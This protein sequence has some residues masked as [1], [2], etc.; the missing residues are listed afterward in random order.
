MTVISAAYSDGNEGEIASAVRTLQQSQFKYFFAAITPSAV[1]CKSIIS[2]AVDLGIAG[3]PQHMW[4][5]PETNLFETGFYRDSLDGSSEKDREIA[6]AIT[7]MGMLFI[8]IPN[9]NEF[10]A[11]LTEMGRNDELYDYFVSKHVRS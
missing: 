6:R 7:G 4:L 9:N 5:W 3:N 8:D 10:D 1:A 11:A 2:N